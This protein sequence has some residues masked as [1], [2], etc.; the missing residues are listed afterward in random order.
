MRVKVS[1]ND[2]RVKTV[3]NYHW[4]GLKCEVC[5]SYNTRQVAIITEAEENAEAEMARADA[6]RASAEHA[7][8]EQMARQR[9][10]S[11]HSGRT[12]LGIPSAGRLN[13]GPLPDRLGRSMSPVRGSYFRPSSPPQPTAQAPATRD[14]GVWDDEG[15]DFW[16]RSRADLRGNNDDDAEDEDEESESSSESDEDMDDDEDEVDELDMALLGHR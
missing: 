6:E 2:C 11:S 4:L 5:G 16:G 13:V 9:R 10:H 8:G 3:A 1:C 7:A 15:L 12:A 14:D